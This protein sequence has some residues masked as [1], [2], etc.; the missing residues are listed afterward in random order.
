VNNSSKKFFV[1]DSKG[2]GPL[3]VVLELLRIKVKVEDW[4]E[5][6]FPWCHLYF[7]KVNGLV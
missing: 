7:K 2:G 4:R 1:V 6:I 5:K 3:A